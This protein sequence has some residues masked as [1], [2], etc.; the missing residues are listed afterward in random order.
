MKKTTNY[1]C[2]FLALALLF[3]LSACN[4]STSPA[5]T[6]PGTGSPTETGE[7]ADTKG[8][9]QTNGDQ[10]QYGGTLDIVN[11]A[12]GASPIGVPWE[13]LAN[14]QALMEPAIETLMRQDVLG[15]MHPNLAEDWTLDMDA[16]T[17]TFNLREGVKFHDGT[18]FNAEAAAWCLQQAMEANVLTQFTGARAD[19]E[20]KLVLEF[21]TY[22]NTSL[23]VLSGGSSGFIS[24][25][26]FEENGI[27]WARDNPVGTG[28]FKFESFTRGVEL[29]YVKNDEYWVAGKP[30]LD[31][32]SYHFIKDQMTQQAAMQQAGD[33]GIDV[34]LTSSGEQ[35]SALTSMGL[36]VAIQSTGPNCL[37]PS[38]TDPDSPL[39][40]LK[41]RQAIY[42]A[43]DRDSIVAARGFGVW[44]PSYQFCEKGRDE[45]NDSLDSGT[46]D[47][48]KAK[49]L[50]EE[51]GYADG[52]STTIYGMPNFADRDALTA[53]QSQLAM[54]GIT[55]SLEFPDSGGYSSM[56]RATWDGLLFHHIRSSANANTS[57][58]FYVDT[59]LNDLAAMARPQSLLDA[60][61]ASMQA[62]EYDTVLS[63][64]VNQEIYDDMTMI[65]VYDVFD[66]SIMQTFVRDAELAQ[67]SSC[68][69][70]PE[71]TWLA[72]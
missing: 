50:M 51:A 28:P 12:E 60:T 7:P 17:L 25:T 65:P 36:D 53:I 16:K 61:T 6:P 41:V 44:Q 13:N 46:Y 59:G 38:S 70:I 32:V 1:L 69:F 49:Q 15:N 27:E 10:P 48:E 2:M 63:G 3:T 22:M 33:E 43:I 40:N 34:L 23:N 47:I 39:A 30:Y 67:W 62:P 52:F 35:V 42:Y 37:V 31:G 56:R 54:I 4:N 55:V 20:Y 14:D 5:S 11:M 64:K 68:K 29:S 45:H 24:P 8:P 9:E 72:E 18:D 66:A 19:G 57:Y 58:R 26:A 71:N 21:D